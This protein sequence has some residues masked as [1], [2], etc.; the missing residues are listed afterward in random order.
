MTSQEIVKPS[1]LVVDDEPSIRKVFSLVLQDI[2]QVITAAEGGEVMAKIKENKV[3]V[4]LLDIRL[5]GVDGVE[6]LRRI[7]EFD[8]QVQVIMV[9]GVKELDMAVKTIKLGAYHYIT[10]PFDVDELRMLVQEVLALKKDLFT[11][12]E[13]SFFFKETLLK[14]QSVKFKK[15]TEEITRLA[16]S[17]GNILISG[18]VGTEKEEVAWEICQKNAGGS[19]RQPI[20]ISLFPGGPELNE[21]RITEVIFPRLRMAA[22]GAVI[23]KGVEFLSPQLQKSFFD[24]LTTEPRPEVRIFTLADVDLKKEVEAGRFREDLFYMLSLSQITIPPLRERK[25]DIELLFEEYLKKY[26]FLYNKKI[27]RLSG[28]VRKLLQAYFWP[29]NLYEMAALVENLILLGSGEEIFLYQLPLQFWVYLTDEQLAQEGLPRDYLRHLFKKFFVG[30]VL[31]SKGGDLSKAGQ[32]LGL[33]AEE[34]KR[35]LKG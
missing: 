32:S 20:Q 26:N 24:F 25:E 11:L 13:Y 19:L 3:D 22:G 15:L 12:Q 8:Q 31:H 18:E 21:L 1:V 29:G 17:A 34:I 28:T 6:L 9:T 30:S 4:V 10:K 14:G 16:G 35:I 23:L 2:C 33:V 7:K 5:P 27:T